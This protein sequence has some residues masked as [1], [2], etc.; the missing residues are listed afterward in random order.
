MKI[1]LKL[2]LL[3]VSAILCFTLLTA[4]GGGDDDWKPTGES[5]TLIAKGDSAK[6][7]CIYE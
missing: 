4:C 5:V 7:L 6:Y 1:S 3:V 2:I